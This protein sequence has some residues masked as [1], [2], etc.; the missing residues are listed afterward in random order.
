MPRLIAS[1]LLL[2]LLPPMAR[3]Q[4]PY[5]RYTD[6]F[7]L[8]FARSQPVVSFTMRIDSANLTGWSVAMH[9][10][11][12]PDTFR[13]AMAAHPEY[14][15]RYWRLVRGLR[16]AGAGAV[17]DTVIPSAARNPYPWQRACRDSSRRSE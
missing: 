17:P 1:A 13:L 6:V 4:N 2:V 3:A 7:E 16:V 15:D 10:R 14:D 8:R 5:Q 9:S 12:L 11:N